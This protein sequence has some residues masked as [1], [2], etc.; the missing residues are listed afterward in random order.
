MAPRDIIQETTKNCIEDQN[1]SAAFAADAEWFMAQPENYLAAAIH[2]QE[3]SRVYH[4]AAWDRLAL[5]IGAA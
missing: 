4:D 5:L 2:K 3:Q 1:T